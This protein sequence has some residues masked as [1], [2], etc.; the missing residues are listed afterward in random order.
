MPVLYVAVGGAIGSLARYYL[1]EFFALAVGTAFPWGTLIV[2]ITGSFV[3]GVIAGGSGADG[4]WIQ[5]PF[6]RQFLM[7]GICGGYTTFSAFS[8][9][10]FGLFQAGDMPRA[11]LYIVASVVLCVLGTWAG[12]AAAAAATR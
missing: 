5:S 2:N 3:I 9:Q 11:M 1:S 10:T 8:L 4:P 6:A 12:F 7:A